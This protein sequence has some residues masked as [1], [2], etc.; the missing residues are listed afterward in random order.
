MQCNECQRA[1]SKNNFTKV[2]CSVVKCQLNAK[3]TQHTN[4]AIAQAAAFCNLSQISEIN[5]RMG[6]K[7]RIHAQARENSSCMYV[8]FLM[9]LCMYVRMYV[10]IYVSM[11]M[12]MCMCMCMYVYD[13]VCVCMCM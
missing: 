2:E 1:R 13:Y 3:Q 7:S 4:A 9:Y 5:N 8:F 12:C 11:S 10:C 6:S